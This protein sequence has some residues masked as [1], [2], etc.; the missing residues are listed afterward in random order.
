MT[1]TLMRTKKGLDKEEKEM[2]EGDDD[3]GGEDAATIAKDKEIIEKAME[4]EMEGVVRNVKPVRQVL[5]KVNHCLHLHFYF[6]L[7][8][9]VACNLFPFIC[10]I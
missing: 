9:C 6:Y 5:Y 1:K 4:E 2:D 10:C 7:L 8:S 3:D